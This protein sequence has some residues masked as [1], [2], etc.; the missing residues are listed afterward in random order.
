MPIIKDAKRS[1]ERHGAATQPELEAQAQ[2]TTEQPAETKATAEPKARP[3]SGPSR[4]VGG[5]KPKAEVEPEAPAEPEA[6]AETTPARRTPRD[7]ATRAPQTDQQ[8][9]KAQRGAAKRAERAEAKGWD[10]FELEIREFGD[11]PADTIQAVANILRNADPIEGANFERISMPAGDGTQFKRD[12]AAG[13]SHVESIT[14]VIVLNA[15]ARVYFQP[16]KPLGKVPPVCSSRD[17]VWGFGDPGDELRANGE[18]CVSCPLSQ[19]HTA[20]KGGAGSACRE[21]RAVG[22]LEDDRPI[23]AVLKLPPTSLTAL[24][25]YALQL[26]ND[27]FELSDVATTI[28]LD[29][30]EVGDQTVAVPVFKVAGVLDET[31]RDYVRLYAKLLQNGAD[32]AGASLLSEGRKRASAAEISQEREVADAHGSTYDDL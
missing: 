16:G 6:Q 13:P 24:D 1:E 32:D 28:S 15:T 8:L 22:I 20:P 10:M 26:F 25:K 30:R 23:A 5:M 9:A 21:L 3:G 18:G 31:S 29:T 14:G 7:V 12:T 27:G 19:R 2:A 11:S 17:G 4:H